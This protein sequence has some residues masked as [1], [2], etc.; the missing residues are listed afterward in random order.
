MHRIVQCI[1]KPNPLV[2]A[3]GL[4]GVDDAAHVIP[5][6]EALVSKD[7]SPHSVPQV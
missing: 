2:V 1:S 4:C 6:C 3:V 7:S 5:I